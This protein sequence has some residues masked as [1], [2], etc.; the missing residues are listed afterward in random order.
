MKYTAIFFIFA[1]AFACSFA[2][3]S[4]PLVYTI[5]AN[6]IGNK[7]ANLNTQEIFEKAQAN[8]HN[9][10]GRSKTPSISS[11]QMNAIAHCVAPFFQGDLSFSLVPGYV[12]VNQAAF[13][14]HPLPHKQFYAQH[15]VAHHYLKHPQKIALLVAKSLLPALLATLVLVKQG[16][17]ASASVTVLAWLYAA[18]N[19]VYRVPSLSRSY[20]DQANQEAA[21]ILRAQDGVN[22][23]EHLHADLVHNP[24]QQSTWHPSS[25]QVLQ[26]LR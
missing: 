25:E 7:D 4:H 10:Y 5:A 17:L 11:K 1:S 14:K 12:H 24:Y 22:I 16:S 13:D 21:R 20:E 9:F 18:Y 8:A 3:A 15:E 6:L 23:V 2:N 19:F 26:D